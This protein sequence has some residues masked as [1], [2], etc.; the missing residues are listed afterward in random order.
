MSPERSLPI[1]AR[2]GAFVCSP[3]GHLRWD[4]PLAPESEG[5]E[6]RDVRLGRALLELVGGRP[7]A[8]LEPSQ[9][10]GRRI[11]RA[12]LLE[13]ARATRER[14]T[15]PTVV[16]SNSDKASWLLSAPPMRGSEYLCD[17]TFDDAFAGMHSALEARLRDERM[18]VGDYL[19]SLGQGYAL[20]G[21][22]CVHLAENK[23]TPETPFAFLATFA[24]GVNGAGEA[25][26]APLAKA[27][28]DFARDQAAL[29][30]LLEPL[31]NAAERC[32]WVGAMID[33]RSIFR[34]MAFTPSE[35]LRLLRDVEALE[36]AGVAVRVPP[37]LVRGARPRV[38]AVARIGSKAPSVLGVD[39]CLDFDVGLALEGEPLEPGELAGLLEGAAGLRWLRGRWVELDPEALRSALAQLEEA[40]RV[41]KREGLTFHDAMRWLAGLNRPSGS[42]AEPSVANTWTG[43]VAGPWLE[44]ALRQ[45][46][47]RGDGLPEP[48]SLRATLRPYQRHGLAFLALASDLGIGVCLADDMGL[49]KT[50]Q[51]LAALVREKERRR[52]P[53]LLVL[54]ASLLGN[55]RAEAARF[56]PTLELAVVHRSEGEGATEVAPGAFDDVDAVLTT[57]GT[58]LR[59]DALVERKWNLVVL[60]EAQAIKNGGTRTARRVRSLRARARVALSGTPVEN[61]V[62]DLH[63][64]FAFLN[65][66][67]LG[68]PT[69]FNHV[70]RRLAA[71]TERGYAPLRALI[72]PY[73][74]RRSKSDRSVVPDLPDKTVVRVEAPLS[75]KQAA[76]YGQ[77]V[78][79]LAERLRGLE[80]IQYRGAALAALLRMKQVCNHPSQLLGDGDYRPDDSGKFRRLR[81][82]A[83]TVFERQERMLVFTQFRELVAPLAA[84]LA[85][86][87]GRPGLT[88]DGSTAVGKRQA[89][90]DRF[91]EED[92]PPF[93]VLSVKAGGTGLNLT[94][95]SHVVHFDR[96][97]NPSVE[98]QATD[99]AFRIGQTRNVLVHTMVCKGTVEERIDA[100]IESK[101]ATADELLAFDGQASL[102]ELGRDELLAALSLDLGRALDTEETA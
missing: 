55:W 40:R 61:R 67:L 60:D 15:L 57:Y 34:P 35:A 23:R 63:S 30:G 71:D 79:E 87:A 32:P 89:L 46:E 42:D 4:R 54:P 85:T 52:G 101:R 72:R 64:L 94:R 19:R 91:Q 14:G 48:P 58:L 92:G 70:V 81:E 27:L 77:I 88:L 43:V 90:V 66:G 13:V 26:H 12:F 74:L 51:V 95:A 96:W 11:A 6:A 83:E 5:E 17:G 9:A 93:F 98:N 7:D 50:L 20:V 29:R 37:S 76:L 25:V 45:L 73:V 80:G 62:E 82:L 69:Q 56:A 41:A 44:G 22:V 10:F 100:L 21:R 3:E 33:D 84:F 49:G 78:D 86:L 75:S 8:A 31:R 28:E 59:T 18:Q 39:T 47:G 97:W 68:T 36:A 1:D 102:T 2:A 38:R 65:A 16:P 24:R 99:R 53:S